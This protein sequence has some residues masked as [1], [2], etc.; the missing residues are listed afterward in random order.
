MDYSGFHD[1]PFPADLNGEEQ[2]ARDY[3]FSL[4]D[5][6]QLRMLHGCLSYE[7]FLDR[8][9]RRMDGGKNAVS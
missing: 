9:A 2:K 1:F 3:F 6:E 5:S 7:N 4:P 8:V